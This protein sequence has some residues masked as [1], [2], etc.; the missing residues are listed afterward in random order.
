[1]IKTEQSRR[2]DLESLAFMLIYFAKGI[3]PWQGI[4]SKIKVEKYAKIGEL[5]RNISAEK[6]CEGLPGNM[7]VMQRRCWYI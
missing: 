6:L 1:V 2:D 5:K 3:L 4:K 7:C